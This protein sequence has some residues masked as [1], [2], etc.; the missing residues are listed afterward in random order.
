MIDF[1]SFTS[2]FQPISSQSRAFFSLFAP[3][4]F[5]SGPAARVFSFDLI[6]LLL[7]NY[8]II[9]IIIL[10]KNNLDLLFPFF[11]PPFSRSDFAMPTEELILKVCQSNTKSSMICI[12]LLF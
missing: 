6:Y 2:R 8:Y 7:L 11:F 4:I 1:I 12:I 10:K 5:P 3:S 9:I